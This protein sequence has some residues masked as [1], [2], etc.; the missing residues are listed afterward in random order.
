MRAYV[1]P[2]DSFEIFLAASSSS[3]LVVGWTIGGERGMP[4]VSKKYNANK[5]RE[6]Y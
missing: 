2:L 1:G 4:L 5:L 6:L 3:P